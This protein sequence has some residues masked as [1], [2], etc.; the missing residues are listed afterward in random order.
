MASNIEIHIEDNQ[1]I[2]IDINGNA[3]S[4]TNFIDLVDVPNAYNGNAS[5]TLRVNS[6]ED[7]LEFTNVEVDWGEIGGDISLQ[8]DIQ[9]A[10]SSSIS[11]HEST[12]N[13]SLIAT[14]LQ[15]IS[16]QDLSTA[17]NSTSQF[18]TLSDIDWVTNVPLNETDP[19]FSAWDKST[20]ISITESQ[21]SDFGTYSTDIHTN[22]SDLQNVSGTNTGDQDLTGLVPYT[23]ATAD[24]NIGE[25]NYI[26]KASLMGYINNLPDSNIPSEVVITS[27][28]N[29]IINNHGITGTVTIDRFSTAQSG[30]VNSVQD[31]STNSFTD[32]GHFL[33][34]ITQTGIRNTVSKISSWNVSGTTLNLYTI[35]IENTI[36][37]SNANHY[38][39]SISANLFGIK[40]SITARSILDTTI[41]YNVYGIYNDINF[42]PSGSNTAVNFYGMYFYRFPT[43]T[44]PTYGIYMNDAKTTVKHLLAKDSQKTYI[45]TGEDAYF[46]YNGTNMIINPKAV[47]TGILDILGVIQTDGY[48]AVDGTAAL[49]GTKVY[50][51]S[52]TSGGS[53]TRKLTFKDGLLVSET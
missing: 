2:N 28:Q 47:G 32:G 17:N 52:D 45:G 33:G 4:P 38:S 22:F 37:T 10:I 31:Y 7:G 1:E 30:L 16:N 46:E 13:H 40:N 20:G 51:V 49:A 12:Y 5:K 26:G 24:I 14:A 25:Y 9:E 3:P 35:G 34:G 29:S 39:G 23:G 21:I 27:S 53:P 15:D 42:V 11:T 44:Q 36:S 19:V 48:R 50:Y 6:T 8:T 41:P 18:I 43:T